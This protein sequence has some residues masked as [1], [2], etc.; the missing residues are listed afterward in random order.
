MPDFVCLSPP[1]TFRVSVGNT[2][3]IVVEFRDTSPVTVTHEATAKYLRESN[4][5]EEQ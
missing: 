2:E 4:N 1:R 5:F 3:D